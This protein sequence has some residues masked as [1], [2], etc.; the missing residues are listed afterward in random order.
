MGEENE[1]EVYFLEIKK[2]YFIWFTEGIYQ[3]SE[4][5]PFVPVQTTFVN[6]QSYLI[7]RFGDL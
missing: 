4:N 3:K 6:F 7:I 5:A 1:A 2:C